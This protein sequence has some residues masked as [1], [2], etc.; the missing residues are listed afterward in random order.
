M[1]ILSINVS[2]K[3]LVQYGTRQIETGIFKQPVSSAVQVF[4]DHIEG[5]EQADLKNHGGL[6]KAV[7][8]YSYQHYSYWRT[9]LSLNEL[10][11]GSFG[12]N[13]TL[14]E[15][16]EAQIQIGDIFKVG[17]VIL[18]VSQPRVPCFKLGLKFDN[19][20]MPRL[21]SKSLRTGVYFSVKQSGTIAPDDTFQLIDKAA[22]SVS[23]QSIFS[24]YFHMEKSAA[25]PIIEKA[26]A[27]E[28]LSE[29]WRAQ[30]QKF[31]LRW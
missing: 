14:S 18:Q 26:V 27:V 17:D 12:E 3:R 15:L 28:G 5:D 21:F 6:G 16:D 30:L 25:K 22:N 31:L 2:K 10:P 20:E 29:E 23:V 19:A 7:Y 8:A 9:E 1:H 13:L 11:F 24:A 4:N